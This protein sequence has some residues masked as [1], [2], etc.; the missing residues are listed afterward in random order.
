MIS[1]IINKLNFL[2]NYFTDDQPSHQPSY[3]YYIYATS[4]PASLSSDIYI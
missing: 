1:E 2:L 4:S 3:Y